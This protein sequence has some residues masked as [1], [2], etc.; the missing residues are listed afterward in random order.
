MPLLSTNLS[1][2]YKGKAVLHDLRLDIGPG[3]IVGVVG[4]SGSGKSTLALSILGLLRYRGGTATGE[5]RFRGADLL[6]MTEGQLR[7]IRGKDIGLILQTPSSALNP[8]LRIGS[9][10]REVWRAHSPRKYSDHLPE[11]RELLDSLDLP[12]DGPFSTNALRRYR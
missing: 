4:Q 2:G 11:M 8:S 12:S 5:A 7:R 1:A 10:L 3:E 9:Q 6:A